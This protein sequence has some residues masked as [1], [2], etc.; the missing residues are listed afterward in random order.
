MAT[1]VVVVSD[2][3]GQPGATTRFVTIGSVTYEVDMTDDE[4]A[5]YESVLARYVEVGRKVVFDKA[6]SGDS[7][8][9]RASGRRSSA[10]TAAIKAW[11]RE[12]GFTFKEKGRLPQ[13]LL[14]AYQGAHSH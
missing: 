10:E 2:I 14:D 4:F 1:S 7:G 6:F 9:R 8:S 13:V 11:G 3:S 5:E 12:N